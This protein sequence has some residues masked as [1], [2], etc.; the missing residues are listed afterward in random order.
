M[1]SAVA[2]LVMVLAMA[3]CGGSDDGGAADGATV[4]T[5]GTSGATATTPSSND[6]TTETT[7][8]PTT[9][10]D[11]STLPSIAADIDVP[12]IEQLTAVSGGGS[13]P[14]LEWTAL[15]GADRYFVFVNA[16]SGGVY[17]AWRTSETA[18][19]VGGFPQLDE[20][21]AGPAVSEGMTWVVMA[22][23]AEGNVVG[24]SPRRPISP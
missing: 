17:W 9:T 1:R 16:P 8:A 19:P 15:D 10:I 21:A 6:S 14:M 23:D 3:A 12:A 13:R 18:V 4:S 22:L 20:D 24:I 2:I 11:V 5:D 7:A